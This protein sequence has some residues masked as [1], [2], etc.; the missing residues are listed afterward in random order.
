MQL[1]ELREYTNQARAK[2]GG[3]KG[4]EKENERFGQ[5]N[6]LNKML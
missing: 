6:L 4:K 2:A 3:D 5:T 1:E